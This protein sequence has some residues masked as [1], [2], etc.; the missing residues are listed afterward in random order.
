LIAIFEKQPR[1]GTHKLK[2]YLFTLA[3]S[4]KECFAGI[5]VKRATTLGQHGLKDIKLKWRNFVDD[6]EDNSAE[7][8]YAKKTILDILKSKAAKDQID[9]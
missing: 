5:S 6:D 2:D 1:M 4:L 9:Q 3:Q 7:E 8:K